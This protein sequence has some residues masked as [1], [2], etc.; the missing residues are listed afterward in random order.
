MFK[1]QRLVEKQSA[2]FSA[3]TN[4]MKSMHDSQMTAVQNIR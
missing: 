1:L 4:A 2:M 3:L